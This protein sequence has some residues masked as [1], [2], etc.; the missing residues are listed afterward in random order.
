MGAVQKFLAGLAGIAP[1]MT[2]TAAGTVGATALGASLGVPLA[3]EGGDFLPKVVSRETGQ[4]QQRAIQAEMTMRALEKEKMLRSQRLQMDMK[5]NVARLAAM[6]P[7]VYSQVLAGRRIPRGGVVIGG[8]P[9]ID[10][11]ED[12]ASSMSQGRF[13]ANAQPSGLEG[14]VS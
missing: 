9:R 4:T 7:D 14:L 8:T 10:L 12:L 2:K 1:G 5:A 13:Q 6:A 3:M 11:M